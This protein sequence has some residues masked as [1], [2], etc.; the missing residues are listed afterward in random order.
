MLGNPLSPYWWVTAP[1]LRTAP[2][3]R[4]VDV[5]GIYELTTNAVQLTDTSVDY[6]IN[7][8]CYNAL[9]CESVVLLKIHAGTP[10]G[11]ENLPVTVVTPNSGSSTVV[12]ESGSNAGTTKKPV[13]DSKNNPVTG[14]DVIGN[15]ERLAYINKRTGV[16]RFLEFTASTTPAPTVQN[17]VASGDV[18]VVAKSK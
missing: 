17:S 7:P 9:P 3:I 12:N 8:V 5:G 2:T 15:T 18:S 6:G 4:R 16:I 1:E 11:G 10:A 14:A 13:T